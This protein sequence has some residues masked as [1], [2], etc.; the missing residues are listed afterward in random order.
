MTDDQ[1]PDHPAQR[2]AIELHD[3]I[4]GEIS[5][6]LGHASPLFGLKWSPDM[7]DDDPNAELLV[8]DKHGA[9]YTLELDVMLHAT[10]KTH[11][12]E[13]KKPNE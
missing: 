5:Y 3:W 2:A 1:P 11:Q 7:P 13:E 10:G 12:Q 8:V 4:S 6:R 9:E